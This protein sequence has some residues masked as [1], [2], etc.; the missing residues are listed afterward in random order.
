MDWSKIKT[1]FIFAFFVL[2]GFLLFWVLDKQ[3][4]EKLP[5]MN[6]ASFE[7]QLTA[8]EIV[9]ENIDTNVNKKQFFIDAIP[10]EF[11][12]DELSQ[13][14]DQDV[15]LENELE[16]II[17][18]FNEPIPIVN[19]INQESMAPILSEKVLFGEHYIFWEYDKLN[20]K[21][22][23]YQTYKNF[24]LFNNQS[25]RII[26]TLNE[27]NEVVGY[28]QTMLDSFEEYGEQNIIEEMKALETLHANGKLKPGSVVK[29]VELGYYTR[30]QL[31]SQVLAPTWHFEINEQDDLFVNAIEGRIIEMNE[32]NTITE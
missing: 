29:S 16:V 2:D 12:L 6:E 9:V 11:N 25:G 19:E 24:P 17:S 22:V 7:E 5:M 26:F 27:N 28:K 20:N 13:L 3:N 21:V 32:S 14:E 10:K 23:Y 4:E 15:I 18:T 31:S 1:I 8:S 30:V